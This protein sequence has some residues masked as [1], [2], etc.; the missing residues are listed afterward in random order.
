MISRRMI[1]SFSEENAALLMN[2]ALSLQEIRC[3]PE[4][5]ITTL[6]NEGENSKNDLNKAGRSLTG[7]EKGTNDRKLGT[8]FR[9]GNTR[10]DEKPNR[11]KKNLKNQ[12]PTSREK[13]TSPR[14]RPKKKPPGTTPEALKN[15]Q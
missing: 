8:T 10:I 14:L 13:L 7:C 9:R 5:M 1:R 11:F 2:I 12:P 15:L 4:T 6:T 3:K